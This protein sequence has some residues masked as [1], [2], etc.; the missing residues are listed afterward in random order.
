MRRT[1][2]FVIFSLLSLLLSLQS[3]AGELREKLVQLK[4]VSRVEELT[5]VHYAEKYLMR[6]TQPV[7]HRHP[8]TG[9]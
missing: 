6:I 8:E 9:S 2:L 5:S 7:D 4:D 3:F 1:F